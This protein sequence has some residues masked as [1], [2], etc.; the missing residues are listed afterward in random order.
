MSPNPTRAA[1]V[2]SSAPVLYPAP[3]GE[4]VPPVALVSPSVTTIHGESR[5]DEYSWLRDRKDPRVLAYLEAENAYTQRSCG[6]PR[7]CRSGST[8]RCGGGSRRRICRS[9]AGGWYSTTPGPRP[10]P[11]TRSSAGGGTAGG[12]GRGPARSRIRSPRDTPIS[13]SGASEVSPDHRLPRLLGGYHRGRG[14]HPGSEGPDDGRAVR[15]EHREHVGTAVAWAND[16]R[17][18]FYMVLDH[19]RRP[20]GSTATTSERP[21]QPRT[22]WCTS[23]ADE[24]FFLDIGRTR[25]RRY[26][27]LDIASHSTSEVR[28][29]WTPTSRRRRS[30]WSQPREQGVEYNV[31][32]HDERF[33][34]ATNDGAPNFRLVSGAGGEPLA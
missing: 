13:G 29:V 4:A 14:V 31:A 6:I 23:E 2:A 10:A 25:S 27:L 24:S 28:V 32:H 1:P 33:F 20:C 15:R 12:P 17:T 21:V 7:H 9:R 11:S 8:R 30:G 22:S 16:S 19:A 26:L 18:L 34:I 5:I 3:A